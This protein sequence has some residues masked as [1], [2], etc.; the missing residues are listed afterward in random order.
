MNCHICNQ[1]IKDMQGSV[2]CHT[3][4]IEAAESKRK[5]GKSKLIYDKEI[6]SL[7]VVCPTCNKR[8]GI[9]FRHFGSAK[10]HCKECE[11]LESQ[12]ESK[13][14]PTEFTKRMR[15]ALKGTLPILRPCSTH[16]GEYYIPQDMLDYY[17]QACNH[18]ESQA[19]QLA[20]KDK[21]HREE[22]FRLNDKCVEMRRAKDKA[23]KLAL[24]SSGT[25]LAST[26]KELEQALKGEK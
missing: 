17:L 6:R 24:S 15:L 20:A 19:E 3:S 16:E 10:Y 2:V 26:R 5:Q 11:R 12:A 14:E 23:I 1:D 22:I 18:L 13:L 21:A 4:C 9:A 25:M 8:L 7:A